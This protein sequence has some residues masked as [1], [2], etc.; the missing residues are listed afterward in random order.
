MKPSP[1]VAT[2]VVLFVI[3]V[4]VPA[5]FYDR[6]PDP[7]PTRFDGHGRASDFTPKPLGAFIGPIIIGFLAVLFMIFPR[8]SPRGYLID[9][10]R[11]PYEIVASTVIGFV[12]FLSMVALSMAMG[13][14]L[15]ADR[16]ILIAI[17]VL[18]LVLGNFMGK[19]TRNFFIG[20]RTPWTLASE[21]VWYRTH[22]VGGWLF[23]MGALVLFAG[24]FLGA[25]PVLMLVVVIAIA[26][27]LTVYS[28]VIYRRIEGDAPDDENN[29]NS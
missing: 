15:R 7:V 11:R 27:G 24:A 16:V 3:S 19:M 23:V 13:A 5:V 2:A 20:I 14:R 18:L 21:E 4:V 17:G 12:F 6:I 22:R 29:S 26:V 10:F 28:Y 1:L 25:G 8:I 9:R